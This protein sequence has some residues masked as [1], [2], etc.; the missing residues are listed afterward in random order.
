MLQQ[1]WAYDVR[2][3]RRVVGSR[4]AAI[5]AVVGVGSAFRGARET[6]SVNSRC[7]GRGGAG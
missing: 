4:W 6:C 3:L 1:L 7:Y 2:L 5:L